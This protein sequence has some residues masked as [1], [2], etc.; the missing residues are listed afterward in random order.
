MEIYYTNDK[1]YISI[2]DS[3]SFSLVN[4]LKKKLYHILD[5]YKINNIEIDIENNDKYDESLIDEL[6]KDYDTKY[7]GIIIVK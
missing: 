1:L 4:K 3:I 6:I 5:I 7:K 2:T